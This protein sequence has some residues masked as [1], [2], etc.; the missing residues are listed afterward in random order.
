V[1]DNEEFVPKPLT[2]K[3]RLTLNLSVTAVVLAVLVMG[4]LVLHFHTDPTSP[5][6]TAAPA[7]TPAKK[8]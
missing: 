3:E 2:R 6:Q 5:Y 8:I 7:Q 1:S 4:G